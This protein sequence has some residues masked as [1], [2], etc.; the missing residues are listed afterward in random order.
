[1][2]NNPIVSPFRISNKH[3]EK[4][5]RNDA[6]K[7]V[8][9][10][11]RRQEIGMDAPSFC[12]L[13]RRSCSKQDQEEF[14][15]HRDIIHTILL[16]LF[17][18]HHQASRIATSALPG[19]KSTDCERAFRGEA[20]SAY[21][22][23]Q[24]I[25]RE[26]HDWYQTERCPACIV[27]HVLNSEPTIRFVAVACLL[28]DNLQGL[29]P[30]DAQKRLPSFD[31]FFDAL[32]GAVREDPFWGND[33]WPD[34]EH[35]ARTLTD[36]VKQLVVQCLVLRAAVE[37]QSL[38]SQSP[39]NPAAYVRC[40]LTQQQT[41]HTVV[42]RSSNFARKHSRKTVEEHKCLAAK[43][44]CTLAA[45]PH[46]GE[47]LSPRENV[48]QTQM[49][50]RSPQ[51]ASLFQAAQ[52]NKPEDAETGLPQTAPPGPFMQQMKLG[53]DM[54]LNS[55]DNHAISPLSPVQQSSTPR[56][57]G[58]SSR[59][60]RR[61]SQ[62]S[63]V[64]KPSTVSRFLNRGNISLSLPPFEK[65]GL[66]S[67]PSSRIESRTHS[68]EPRLRLSTTSAS[69]SQATQTSLSTPAAWGTSPKDFPQGDYPAT[70]P[71][72]PPEDD[73]HVLWNTRSNMLLF[74]SHL[75]RDPG[76]MSMDE[77]PNIN[78]SPGGA[79]R[80][81]L[82]SPSDG[83][84]NASPS[85]SDE[86]H[87]S[88]G[89]DMDCDQDSW[90]ENA[91]ESTVS[92]LPGSNARGE[93]VKLVSQTLPYPYSAE[94]P[95][96]HRTHEGVFSSLVQVIQ[97]RLRQGQ[98]PYINVT[99]AVP[100]QFSLTNLPTSP[101]GSPRCM[102]PNND[103]FN[104]TVFSSAAVVS[105]YHD[106]RG[107]IQMKAPQHF[108]MPI[109]PPQSVHISVL[110]R[111]IPPSSAQEYNDLFSP[112]RPSFLVDRLSELSPDGGSLLFIYPTRR[113]GSA[114]KSQ[115]LGPILD[116]LL[117]QLV[118]VNELSADI[119][120]YLGKLSS[121]S[122]MEDFDTLK[123]NLSMLCRALS[124]SSSQ[125]SIVDAR[126]GSAYLDRDLWTEWYIHQEKARMKEVLSLYCQNGR[127][128]STHKAT[129]SSIANT[130]ILAAD[131]E[132][133]SAMLLSEII[134]GIRRRPYESEPRDGIELGVF[135]IR[136]SQ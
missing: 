14:R 90:L 128:F 80:V 98:S 86:S 89:G 65:L 15:L 79:S 126:K 122:H 110:E 43:V 1:M 123:N 66:S 85:S 106:F 37:R 58:G 113:G 93:P 34:I 22:W 130:Y 28:S 96:P 75:N 83:L 41:G 119:G 102:L 45:T 117:R 69:N 116:P 73:E 77:D 115:Y 38:Q 20:R 60:K 70:L 134:D 21:A 84:S 92:S 46:P 53:S 133:T 129:S 11:L 23:L 63:L 24:C 6:F 17:L 44:D 99:H 19:I 4:L 7:A 59:L 3:S 55:F 47:E 107:P 131:K 13:H 88:P 101:P 124:S 82:G 8:R 112:S 9:D 114:F 125:F 127:R 120:R 16:P 136:R 35:R 2:S 33:F 132:V 111:Y 76:P 48:G 31:F 40:D 87:N 32:E 30:L 29:S 57:G 67:K 42:M 91:I 72:T 108:P 64:T 12:S 61:A 109:V 36:G 25:L 74:S 81:G 56:L 94:K 5:N 103:Y 118:V 105:A 104:A 97:N 39:C 71:P 27:L 121:V 10:H 62:G 50:K 135:V 78:N 18:L 54:L 49:T 68:V 95:T 26:E 100:E 52:A 51:L